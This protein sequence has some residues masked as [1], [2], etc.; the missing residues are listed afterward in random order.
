MH[1]SEVLTFKSEHD[2]LEHGR[3]FLGYACAT[4]DE[5]CHRI[6]H[7]AASSLNTAQRQVIWV[8]PSPLLPQRAQVG[9]CC[10]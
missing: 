7:E 2:V 1:L 4:Q 6:D 8:H 5:V 9:Y 3:A 10:G